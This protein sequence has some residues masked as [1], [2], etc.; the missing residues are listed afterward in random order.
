MDNHCQFIQLFLVNPSET[1]H[2]KILSEFFLNKMFFKLLLRMVYSLK[3]GHSYFAIYLLIR[4]KITFCHIVALLSTFCFAWR[5][6]EL[7][8]QLFALPGSHAIARV[9][10]FGAV[11][12]ALGHAV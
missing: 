1:K 10:S 8:Q 5:F 4:L 6:D 2:C 11:K 7:K 3:N 12:M 9:Q